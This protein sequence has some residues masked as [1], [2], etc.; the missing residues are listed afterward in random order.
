MTSARSKHISRDWKVTLSI[1]VK[2]F[3][4]RHRTPL[5]AASF[6]FILASFLTWPFIIHPF[7]TQVGDIYGDTFASISKFDAI[8]SLGN[9]PLV[10][11]RISSIAY[12][13]GVRSNVGVDRVSFFSTM[14]LWTLSSVFTPTFAHNMYAF[15][16]YFIT[17]FVMYLFIRKYT[18]S[19]ALSLIGGSA[20]ITFPL[21]ISLA[22]AAPVYMWSWLYILPIWAM[23]ELSKSYSTKK[24]ILASLSIIPGVFWT[25]YF[26]LHVFL[27]M[28]TCLF[29][30]AYVHF[31]R[32]RTL[33][34]N[35]LAILIIVMSITAI[36]YVIIG[37][38]SATSTVIPGRPLS[39][40]YEQSLNPLMLLT[41]SPYTA[42]AAP[43]YNDFIKPI[44]PRGIDVVLFAGY[45]ICLLALL[46]AYAT[47]RNKHLTKDMRLIGIFSIAIAIVAFS[48]SLA[49]TIVV[50]GHHI[51]TPNYFVV[52]AVP[53]LRAGQRLVVVLMFG[54]IILAML[55]LAYLLHR[56]RKHIRPSILIGSIA[57]L[58]TIEYTTVFD[59]LTTP[60][61]N[62]SSMS[63]L[64]QAS[65][66]IVAEYINNSLV[67]YPGQL[68]CKAYLIHHQI[69]VNP[70]SLDVYTKPGVQA[71]ADAIAKLPA[72]DQLQRLRD[73][74]VNYFIV[75]GTS[76]AT[77][78]LLKNASYHLFAHDSKFRIYTTNR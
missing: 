16:G 46:G 9:N 41:P 25:P 78:K 58:I 26:T 55:G 43:I 73:L 68:A 77:E 10:D 7:S 32:Y 54:L 53:A 5:L 19:E 70:C 60:V 21:F 76:G 48:F 34:Y 29:V 63:Q 65:K 45:T 71:T 22:R 23:I 20:F 35:H 12:P 2:S 17:A 74:G 44:R 61:S 51:P 50:L 13:D 66:G 49:P 24:L 62:P 33:P 30:Y 36:L 4:I 39:D 57:I 69:T 15:L 52:H 56:L 72:D 18:K 64:A 37:H 28:F 38:S 40:A 3:L 67:G 14:F 42:F 1:N 11:G 6:F 27:I 47:V 31:R 8:K 75:D 59:R